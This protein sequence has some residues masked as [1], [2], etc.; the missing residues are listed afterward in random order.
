MKQALQ[1]FVGSFLCA[2]LLLSVG[3]G[4]ATATYSEQSGDKLAPEQMFTLKDL[5][6]K[7][8]SL[9]EELAKNKAVLINFWATWCPPCREEIPDLVRLHEQYQGQ[10][11][12]VLGVNLGESNKKASSFAQKMS[13]NYPVLLD[14]DEEAATDYGI[15]GIP[16]S[17]LVKSDGTIVGE[18]HSA[19]KKLFTDVENSLK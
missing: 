5:S 3:C 1:G 6:G 8:V 15:V 2:S 13:I 9:K 12:E 16:T 7:D 4:G 18:Y 14:S 11:F 10:S 19:S 17:L